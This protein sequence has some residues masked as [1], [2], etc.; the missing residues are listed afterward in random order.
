MK[1]YY[2]FVFLLLFSCKSVCFAQEDTIRIF[3]DKDWNEIPKSPTAAFYRIAYNNDN[4]FWQVND[5]YSDGKLQMTGV[6]LDRAMIK[7]QGSFEWYHPSGKLK[8]K[9]TYMNGRLIDEEITY[10]ENGQIDTYRHFDNSG[11]QTDEKMYKP[12][13]SES[14]CSQ[15]EYPGGLPE[16]YRFLTENVKYPRSLRRRNI[17]GKVFV[18]FIVDATGKLSQ[19]FVLASPHN[20]MAEEAIRVVRAMPNWKPAERDGVKVAIKYNLPINF[21]LD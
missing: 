13:G 3:Y 9:A 4:G 6:F 19:L 18:S 15:A 8:T 1:L 14:V 12:D 2:S 20:L 7:K 11:K 17:E 10:Y 21:Q 5:Y 16:M